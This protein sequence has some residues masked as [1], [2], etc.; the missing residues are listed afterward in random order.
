M[1]YAETRK[2]DLEIDFIICDK[3]KAYLFECKLNNN[4]DLKLNDTASILQDKVRNLLGDRE[5]AGRYVIYQG[6]D[7][8]IEQKGCTV[9]CTNNWDINFE[10]F[11]KDVE[12]LKKFP[13]MM[14]ILVSPKDRLRECHLKMKI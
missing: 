13:K 11:E 8:L 2:S 4:D 12:K 3:R 6:H 9:I 5:L 14:N 10:N 7:K 1:Y